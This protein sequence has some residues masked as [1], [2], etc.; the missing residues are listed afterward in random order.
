MVEIGP[1][2]VKAARRALGL[3]AEKFARV[4]GIQGFRTIQRWESGSNDIPGPA[5]VLI[6]LI[7]NSQQARRLLGLRQD[8]LDDH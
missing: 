7:M 4:I 8:L 3:S 2:E 6:Y 5:R 1:A